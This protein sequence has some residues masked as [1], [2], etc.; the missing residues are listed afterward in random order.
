MMSAD[1]FDV[2]KKISAVD[3]LTEQGFSVWLVDFGEPADQEGGLHRD[4]SDHVV[5]VND[6]IDFVYAQVGK[7][8]HLGGYCQGGIFCYLAAAYRKSENVG[9]VVSFAAPVNLYE[10]FLPGVSDEATLKVL[11]AI[12]GAIPKGIL[13]SAIPGWASRNLFRM[14]APVKQLQSW[15]SLLKMIDNRSAI[16][17]GEDQRSFMSDGFV[18]WPGPAMVEFMRQMLMGNRMVTGGCVIEGRT[19]SLSDISCPMLAVIGG[20]DTIARP[21]SVRGIV[22]AAPNADLYQLWLPNAGH[23]GVLVGGSAMKNTWST[24]SSWLSWLDDK[25]QRPSSIDVLD[26]VG[27]EE[28]KNSLLDDN[29]ALDVSK[30]VIDMSKGFIGTVGDLFGSTKSSLSTMS[31]DF[32]SRLANLKRLQKLD[33]D[34]KVGFALSLE[35][36]SE[37]SP[38]DT[39][40]LYDE[41][42]YT[43]AEA[44]KR[45]DNIVRGL[46]SIGV[47]RGDHVGVFM[48]ARPTALATNLAVNRLG[49]VAVQLCDR[50]QLATELK[51][52]E[53]QHLIA[54][55]ENAEAGVETFDGQTYVLGG[56]GGSHRELPERAIDMEIIDPSRVGLPDWYQPSPGSADE[57][58]FISFSCLGSETHC[59]KITHR[60]WAL[61]ALGT[62]YATRMVKGD[63]VYCWTPLQDLNG[64]LVAV[65][66]SLVAGARV[67]LAKQFDTDTFWHEVRA[68]G[69]NIV[70][71]SGGML[72]ELVDAPV[73]ALERGHKIR[74]FAGKGMP[75]DLGQRV[76][77]RLENVMI[78]EYYLSSRH[79][80]YLANLTMKKTGAVF[81][82]LP[83]SSN[84]A[85]VHWDHQKNLPFYDAEGYLCPTPSGVV[86]ML[87]VQSNA[88]GSYYKD[89]T[90]VFNVFEKGDCWQVSGDLFTLDGDGDYHFIDRA[91]NLILIKDEAIPTSPIETAVN[92]LNDVS[93][94]AAYG[95]TLGGC[96]FQIPV[97]AVVL[98]AEAKLTAS[99]LM[100][101]RGQLDA[102]SCP[103]VVRVLNSLPMTPSYQVQKQ[104]LAEAGVEPGAAARG[105]AF[106]F[107]EQTS[108]Y[109]AL[110]PA[111][112]ARLNHCLTGTVTREVSSGKSAS[113]KKPAA[114]SVETEAKAALSKEVSAKVGKQEDGL[115]GGALAG[116]LTDKRLGDIDATF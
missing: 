114:S 12:G 32:S 69:A 64:M 82:K 90:H 16:L 61:Y 113:S 13:P 83:G 71:Y 115:N 20:G 99:S 107:N 2:S 48:H 112:L 65:S 4:M 72:R 87:L 108:K 78:M 85:L 27:S 57:V 49:A 22:E 68:Y 50:S 15:L 23:L 59:D 3:Y 66:A 25:A 38:N 35:E 10:N 46:V 45:V 75:E 77:S 103:L 56:A 76:E 93:I 100:A 52:A 110:T 9:S 7:P 28:N 47:R 53:V 51:L 86:G 43:Y 58:A 98:K 63:T 17:K 44:N 21:R 5:A 97:V 84:V 33:S 34:S 109:E 18:A 94:A 11:E 24:V 1:V 6:A 80:A 101:V 89:N 70:C 67:G 81:Q 116:D 79:N 60:Q 111:S 41:R 31:D 104:V 92:T 14:L 37:K 102:K 8:V 62:A 74:L 95:V 30:A 19:V 54:D 96:D 26:T 36:Q 42:A 29:L 39:Y 106:C 88:G 105:P 91:S 73:H 40:F 55:P